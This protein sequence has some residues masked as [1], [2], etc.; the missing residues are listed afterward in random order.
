VVGGSKTNAIG[1][2]IKRWTASNWMSGPPV[3]D[4]GHCHF[5]EHED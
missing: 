5:M 1:R 2:R 4:I 3:I